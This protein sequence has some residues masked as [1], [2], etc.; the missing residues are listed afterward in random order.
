MFH[1]AYIT[2]LNQ[3]AQVTKME[4]SS[5]A[6]TTAAPFML[7]QEELQRILRRNLR[8]LARIFNMESRKAVEVSLGRVCSVQPY[9][10]TQPCVMYCNECQHLCRVLICR[11]GAVT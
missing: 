6:S 11:K 4:L 2:Q 8:G 5:N 3:S 9:N 10:I 1:D 7:T